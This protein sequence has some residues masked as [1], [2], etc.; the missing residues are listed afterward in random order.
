M[1]EVSKMTHRSPDVE[2]GACFVRA[3]AQ[4]WVKSIASI[5]FRRRSLLPG[6]AAE[7]RTRRTLSQRIIPVLVAAFVVFPLA[8]CLGF[9]PA[10]TALER[11]DPTRGYRPSQRSQHRDAGKIII[12]LAFSG[13]GTRAAAFAYGVL[14]ELRDTRIAVDGVQISLLEEV[15]SISGVSGG[16][17]PAAYYG[18]FG[19]RIFEEFEPR[20]L[21][22]NVQRA[23]LLRAL[24]P[25]NLLRLFTPWLS[26]SDL[27]SSYY[28]DKVYD[29]ATF[30]DLAQA[31]GPLIRINATDLS[32]G[33]RI[34]FSQDTFD[35]ICSDLDGFPI[36]TALAASS[37]VPMLLSPI[38][39][40]NYA[41]T[42]GY[43]P[44]EWVKEAL[45][46]RHTDPRRNRSAQT[47]MNFTDA[48]RKKYIHLVDGGISDNLALRPAIDFV[49]AVGGI[50][51]AR[52]IVGAEMPDHLVV[53]AVNAETDPNPKIDLSSA[54]PSF[55]SLMSSVSGSQIRRYNF[56]T[57]LL[58]RD[59]VRGWGRDL[60]TADH[61]VTSHM[62]YVGFDEVED[63]EE[64]QYLKWLPTSFVLKDREVDRLRQAGRR[65]LRDSPRFQQLLQVL[66]D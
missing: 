58:V 5:R 28:N 38:T 15:D 16:S 54:S 14:E 13:G 50:E 52:Q 18:L 26:R 56:E 7:R 48:E 42:C 60:S 62:V 6:R 55:A 11:H 9:R 49:T 22:R 17:F 19:D 63:E 12:Y 47:F 2:P 41:G 65:L 64:R 4:L 43:D 45:A 66:K 3:E 27:A 31:E 29:G 40:Q 36:S 59:M 21:K 30:A 53:I 25:W 20:F 39:L 61:P 51:K 24:R 37:A 32:S 46:N 10:N 57:L 35:I 44:P 33:D 8:G 1:E 23:L 34:T